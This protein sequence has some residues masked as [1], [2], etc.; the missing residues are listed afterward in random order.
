MSTDSTAAR[1]T[2]PR[3]LNARL[4]VVAALAAA[5][6]L[7]TLPVAAGAADKPDPAPAQDCVIYPGGDRVYSGTGTELITRFGQVFLT[8]RLSLVSGAAVER[9]TRTTVGNCELLE[10]PNG[11]ARAVCHF[12]L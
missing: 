3:R 12:T 6:I 1:S 5:S 2:S 7:L 4:L 8:C 11:Q 9:V 10:A